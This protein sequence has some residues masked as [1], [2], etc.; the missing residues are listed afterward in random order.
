MRSGESTVIGLPSG[1]LLSGRSLPSENPPIGGPSWRG[2]WV[3]APHHVVCAEAAQTYAKKSIK[4]VG[5]R[6]AADSTHSRAMFW[7][8]PSAWDRV[9]Q[10]KLSISTN[11][12]SG[13]LDFCT[14]GFTEIILEKIWI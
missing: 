3:V 10:I 4:K 11:T 6:A 12:L 9:V 7:A 1:P 8:E 13:K 2:W 5:G 14:D